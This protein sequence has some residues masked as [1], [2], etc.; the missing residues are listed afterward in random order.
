MR[1]RRATGSPVSDEPGVPCPVCGALNPEDLENC[2]ACGFALKES[3]S[4]E[5]VDALLEDVLELSAGPPRPAASR[6]PGG[7]R[8]GGT[9]P[10]GAGRLLWSPPRGKQA[11]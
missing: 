1:A 9:G 2:G 3:G 8:P 5:Q 10:G 7:D 4:G 6:A 11:P